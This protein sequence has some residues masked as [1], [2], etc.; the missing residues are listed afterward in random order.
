M[1][2][3]IYLTADRFP[4]VRDM[5]HNRTQEWYTH[6]DRVVDYDVFLYVTEGRM[7]VIEEGTEYFVGEREHLFLRKGRHHW[8]KKL[9]LPGTSWWWIHFNTLR[10]DDTTYKNPTIVPKI[11]HV[12]P[13]HYQ[14]RIPLP[15]FGSSSLHKETEARLSSIYEAYIHPDPR[16]YWMTEVSMNAYRLFIG[17]QELQQQSKVQQQEA[18]P[19]GKAEAH[20]ARIL[21]YVTLHA[22]EEFDSKQLAKFMG[23]NYSHLSSLFAKRTGQT[24]IEVHTRL[25][26]NRALHLMRT[27]SL[28]ISEISERLGYQNPFYFTRVFK[29][30]MGEAPSSYLKHIYR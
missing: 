13:D 28:N 16:P 29:K 24:I 2:N 9:T 7:Q 1:D 18:A 22:E 15:K 20:V 4:L 19:S 30:V 6:P 8:G 14:F 27:T 3:D 26:M 17:L 11:G 5:G 10:D 25:R 12:A 21:D 23:L